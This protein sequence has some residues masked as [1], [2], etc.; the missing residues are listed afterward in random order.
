VRRSHRLSA[1]VVWTAAIAILSVLYMTLVVPLGAGPDEPEHTYRAFEIALG[2]LFPQL[3]S[4]VGH[5]QLVACRGASGHLAPP[6][7]AGGPLPPALIA[8]FDELY[9]L[10]HH[11]LAIHFQ[12]SAYSHV[13][14]TVLGG[15]PSKFGNFENTA[16]YSPVNYVPEIV[17]FWIAQHTSESA[18]AAL[19]SARLVTGL[20]WAALVTWAVALTP[21][22]KW[23]FSMV[24]LIPT[25]LSQGAMINADATSL[26]VVALTAAYALR[27]ADGDGPLRRRQLVVLSVLG[28]VLGLMKLP[29]IVA[30]AGVLAL[31]WRRLGDGRERLA[32]LA[33]VTVPGLAAAIW[34]SAASN[35]YF[36]PYRDI[37]Y[38]PATRA[39]ISQSRQEHY[40]LSHLDKL[41]VIL[42]HSAIHGH[43]FMLWEVVGTLGEA[44]LPEWFAIVWLVLFVALAIGSEGPGVGRASRGWLAAMLAV[45]FLGTAL[46]L[47]VTWSGVGASAISG[48]HGRYF[49][50]V[51]IFAVPLLAALG[52]GRIRHRERAIA[53]AAMLITALSAGTMFFYASY[54]YYG[55][56]PWQVVPKLTSVLL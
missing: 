41:P 17:I 19:F 27:A 55:Q 48:M 40:M 14:G 43:L 5:P 21:R 50:L 1:P 4:C 37:V 16:L 28:L 25:A 33:V 51:L 32:R 6:L 52:G 10:L 56:G 35:A 15:K 11:G 46:A 7:R 9:K 18:V 49:T 13:L 53:S 42:W 36:V 24:V 31:V 2:H 47:Y 22:W 54:H 30:L 44:G 3:V 23:L 34:W 12:P 39:F 8:T 45:Y 38:G 26:G 20:I 29:L